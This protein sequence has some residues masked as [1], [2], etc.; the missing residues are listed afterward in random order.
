MKI[1]VLSDVHDHV[2]NLQAA[3]ASLDDTEAL[4]YCGD[5]CSPF[6]V[7]LLAEGFQNRPIEI[8][9]GNNDGDL[10]RIAQ[11]AAKH[12]STSGCTA[13]STR[14]SWAAGTSRSTTFP[15]SPRSSAA[16]ARSISSASGTI[17]PSGSSEPAARWRSTRERCSGTTLSTDGR[18]CHFR[19][20]RHRAPARPPATRSSRGWDGPRVVPY[21]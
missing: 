17:T 13:R 14:T 20:L 16:R 6:V 21:P 7:G 9:F 11:N 19:R 12:D 18:A 3:L 15:R 4:L 1:A 5:L 2:W 10:F 8:V